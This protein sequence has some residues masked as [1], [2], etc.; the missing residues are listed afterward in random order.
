M[1]FLF[2]LIPTGSAHR[3]DISHRKWIPLEWY[4][5]LEYSGIEAVIRDYPQRAHLFWTVCEQ[6]SRI[7]GTANIKF[8]GYLL[9]F[10][11]RIM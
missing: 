5:P 1:A 8:D 7:S 10:I 11:F 2:C 4:F 9:K 3:N 6:F